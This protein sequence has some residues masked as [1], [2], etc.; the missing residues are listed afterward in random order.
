MFQNTTRQQALERAREL[1][2]Q[3]AVGSGAIAATIAVVEEEDI[4]L[5]YLPGNSLRV[6]VRVVGDIASSAPGGP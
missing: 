1:A 4:P 2:A 6:R 5:S 3:R